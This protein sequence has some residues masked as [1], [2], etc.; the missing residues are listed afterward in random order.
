MSETSDSLFLSN[1]PLKIDPQG[2]LSISK[3]AARARKYKRDLERQGRT[4]DVLI[5]DHLRI[6]LASDRYAGN[7]VRETTESGA[8]KALP[9]ELN[10]PKDHE[11]GCRTQCRAKTLLHFCI[12]WQ[13]RCLALAKPVAQRGTL[14]N[15]V[16]AYSR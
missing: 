8:L 13:R 2:A 3:V 14:R 6:S 5:I 9:K 4:L 12:D 10:V 16:L 1:L 11:T 15:A 7:P